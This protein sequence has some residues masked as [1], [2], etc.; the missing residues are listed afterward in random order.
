MATKQPTIAAVAANVT[1]LAERVSTVE[2][3]AT[4]HSAALGV[5]EA[6]LDNLEP[7]RGQVRSKVGVST[8]ALALA[9]VALIALAALMKGGPVGPRGPQ[10][11]EG[12]TIIG[13]PGPAGDTSALKAEIASLRKEIE[14]VKVAKVTPAP[15]PAPAV[16]EATGQ[17]TYSSFELDWLADGPNLVLIR[18]V[19]GRK[20]GFGPTWGEPGPE[21]KKPKGWEGTKWLRNSR[22]DWA[23]G[24]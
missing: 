3:S 7:L 1:A 4:D 9:L 18:E 21:V 5:V 22:G 12:A 8:F 17:P 2:R 14:A 6:T 23:L 16:A 19:G 15:A 24:R 13:P 11:P 10:G 20:R